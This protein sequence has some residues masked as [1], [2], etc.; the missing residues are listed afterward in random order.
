L[1]RDDERGESA[2]E[3]YWHREANATFPWVQIELPEGLIPEGV[4]DDQRF[5]LWVARFKSSSPDCETFVHDPVASMVEG[6]VIESRDYHVTTH[7]INHE[8][9][10]SKFHLFA[11]ATKSSGSVGLTL[12]KVAPPEV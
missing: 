7:V 10:L 11:T 8:R 12:Y 3:W 9:T 1:E 6:G 5:E 2:G 4:A